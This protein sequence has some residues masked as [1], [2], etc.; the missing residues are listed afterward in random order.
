MDVNLKEVVGNIQGENSSICGSPATGKRNL[1]VN[2]E[3]FARGS[4]SK[5]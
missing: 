2:L 4:A 3:E 5:D 1:A